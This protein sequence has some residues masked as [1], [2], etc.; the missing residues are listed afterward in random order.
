[1][2]QNHNRTTIARAAA[3][4]IATV[5]G[6]LPQAHAQTAAA[7]RDVAVV[8]E[9]DGPQAARLGA[10]VT[11]GIRKSSS[12]RYKEPAS[13]AQLTVRIAT[14]SAQDAGSI[15]YSASWV[16]TGK[17][18]LIDRQLA[19]CDVE[20]IAACADTV[21]ARTDAVRASLAGKK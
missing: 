19:T 10:L 3:A 5:A 20:R 18:T 12:M 16:S 7:V 6:L 14:M 8:A 1:M 21:V 11:E 4:A 2:A 17:D 13:K 15:V 9:A